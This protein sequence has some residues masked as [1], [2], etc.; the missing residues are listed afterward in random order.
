[1]SEIVKGVLSGGL[2]LV[3]G[4]ILPTALNL[5]LLGIFVIPSVPGGRSLID[6]VAPNEAGKAALLLGAAVVCGLV[7]NVLQTPLYRVLEGYLLWPQWAFQ[8]RRRRHVK[9][10][11]RIADRL[12][13]IR[14]YQDEMKALSKQSEAANRT[15]LESIRHSAEFSRMTRK[16]RYRFAPQRALLREE[17]RRYPVDDDQILPTRLGNAI[18]RFEEYGWNHYRLDSQSLWSRL[19][20][21]VPDPVRK[22][23]DTAQVGVDFFVCLLYG[24]IAVALAALAAIAVGGINKW[25]LLVAVAVPLGFVPA[26]YRLAVAT[27]DQ[28]AV[29]IQALVDLGRQ[30]LATALGLLIPATIEDERTMWERVSRFSS[31]EYDFERGKLLS[32]FRAKPQGDDHHFQAPTDGDQRKATQPKLPST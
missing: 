2:A 22:Q 3:A 15:K 25:T 27:T 29:A 11:A 21:V 32:E 26:W 31:R 12:A 4:W 24:H 9:N 8:R 18:R 20:S 19:I 6:S 28:W 5:L 7:L 13:L 10:K 16:D 23:V 17:L 30:P 1:M 14:R